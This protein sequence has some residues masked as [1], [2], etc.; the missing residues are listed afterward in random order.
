ME[1]SDTEERAEEFDFSGA[2]LKNEDKI[3]KKKSVVICGVSRGGTSFAGSVFHHLGVPFSRAGERHIGRRYEHRQLRAAFVAKDSDAV[4]RIA[5]DFSQ[6]YDTW[7]WKLPAIHKDFTFL[8]GLIPNPHYVFIIKEPL[9]VAVRKVELKGKETLRSLRR[10]LSVYQHLTDLALAT[11]QPLML[12]SYDR[13]VARME[14]FLR[15]AAKF[16]GVEKYDSKKVLAAIRGDGAR[17]FRHEAEELAARPRISKAAANAAV[18]NKLAAIRA[19]SNG[20]NDTPV[21]TENSNGGKTDIRKDTKSEE[22]F[23]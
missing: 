10:V 8:A 11:E 22:S 6:Q 21:R 19:A 17:Y 18:A 20:R 15:D 23:L 3:T 16:G 7:A 2:W 5:T 13:A 9:S 4:K 1:D 12:I 14:P